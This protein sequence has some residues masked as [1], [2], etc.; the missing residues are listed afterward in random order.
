[1]EFKR[2]TLTQLADMICGNHLDGKPVPFRY[3]SSSHL[4]RFFEDCN[5]DYVHDGSTR[6]VW[7]H[8]RLVEI[9]QEP[10]PDLRT[11]PDSF[12]RVIRVL[13]DNEDATDD[14]DASRTKA[15][16][17]LNAALAREGFAAFYGDDQQCYLRHIGTNTVA[18][19]SPNP[20]RHF[21]V[22]EQK[23]RT[24][25]ATYLGKITEDELI[26]DV[27]LPLFRQLGFH[28]VTV[29]GHKDK[30]LEYGKDLWM[31]YTL[32]T[33]H[34]LYFGIQ[35]KK[36]KIDSSGVSIANVAEIYNQVSMMLGHEIFDPEIGKRVLVDHAY[37]VA[38]GEITK[39]ARNWLGNKLDA[40]KRNQI[41]FMDRDDIL[42]LF[43][44]TN[45]P[46]PAKALP[47]PPRAELDDEIPF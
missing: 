35:A 42:N 25:L 46:L 32:P 24:Q 39:A 26:G 18:Q 20:H 11:P 30:A 21:T 36:D 41:I 3:R 22:L 6:N 13:M 14:D 47:P 15:L 45:M 19:P 27:L 5:T 29:A 40:T 4:T 44:V 28:R 43:I 1:M 16:E 23:K 37:I 8:D 33:T 34:V 17:T 12:C 10:H 38:G 9:L 7:V 31:K 2:R